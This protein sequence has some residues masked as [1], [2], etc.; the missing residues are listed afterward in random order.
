MF[1]EHLHAKILGAQDHN[2]QTVVARGFS[3]AVRLAQAPLSASSA[4]T[5]ATAQRFF[6]QSLQ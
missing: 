4:H 6:E 5:Q 3:N 2:L 1:F